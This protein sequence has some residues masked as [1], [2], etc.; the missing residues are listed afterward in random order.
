MGG[1]LDCGGGGAGAWGEIDGTC[2]LFVDVGAVE[3]ASDIESGV[4]DGV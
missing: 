3:G 4:P 2:C 1:E